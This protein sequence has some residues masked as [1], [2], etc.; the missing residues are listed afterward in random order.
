MCNNTLTSG[1][2]NKTRS[3]KTR[4]RDAVFLFQKE[5]FFFSKKKNPESAS[6]CRCLSDRL[7]Y[8]Y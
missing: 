7:A 5:K 2:E 6:D 4:P 3:G 8:K 1:A